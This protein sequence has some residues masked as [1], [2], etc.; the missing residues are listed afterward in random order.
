MSDIVDSERHPEV[1][2][3][4]EA[5]DQQPSL[6]DHNEDLNG[7]SDDSNGFVHVESSAGST[8]NAVDDEVRYQVSSQVLEIL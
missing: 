8:E 1:S 6:S 5:R 7:S 2:G 4:D 3:A